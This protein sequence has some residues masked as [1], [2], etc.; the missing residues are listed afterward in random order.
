MIQYCF[1]TIYWH[2]NLGTDIDLAYIEEMC[3]S[4][5]DWAC[6][7]KTSR[8]QPVDW[9]NVFPFLLKAFQQLPFKGTQ[10]ICFELPWMNV[11]EKGGYQ[12][13]HF[14]TIG[15]ARLSYC[16]F[17]KLPPGSG[18][19]GF[20]NENRRY[21]ASCR[22][23]DFLD[24]NA[25]DDSWSFP[26]V[27]EGDILIFPSYMVHQVTRH[28]LEDKRITISGNVVIREDELKKETV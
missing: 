22:L 20:F 4:E 9:S 21:M 11:Y 24:I 23:S 6:N 16:Y 25:Q 5:T 19:F 2:F 12:E 8:K 3:A 1:P 7:V 18:K 26:D 28:L 27:K 15:D 10:N 17:Y 14:H 13:A